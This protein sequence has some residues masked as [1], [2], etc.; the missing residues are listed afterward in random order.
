MD[1]D[2]PPIPPS[3][4]CLRSA[5]GWTSAAIDPPSAEPAKS[6]ERVVAERLSRSGQIDPR[7]KD[8]SGESSLAVYYRDEQEVSEGFFAALGAMG[9][10]AI[11]PV[12]Q[13]TNSSV[14]RAKP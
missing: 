14:R 6:D 2:K 13:P 5:S 3:E 8:S 9:I 10:A 11:E 4:L 12:L 7:R 1:K